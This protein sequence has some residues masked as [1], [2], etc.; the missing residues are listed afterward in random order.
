MQELYDEQ[1]F[2]AYQDDPKRR[3]MYGQEY[4]RIMRYFEPLT[5]PGAYRMVLDVGCGLGQFLEWFPERNWERHGVEVSQYAQA[6]C[7][8]KGIIMG[9]PKMDQIVDEHTGQF[10]QNIPAIPYDLV[11]FRGSLQHMQLPC[12]NLLSAHILLKP[13]GIL[14]ILATPDTESTCYRLWGTLPALNP[15]YNYHLFG[16]RQLSNALEHMGF[17]VLDVEHPYRDTPYANPIKDKL[18]FASKLLT[19]RGPVPCWPG[20]MMEIYAMKGANN[21]EVSYGDGDE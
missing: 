20:N 21:Y 19:G 12:A 13:G 5:K 10:I 4:T 17:D 6:V 16:A 11:I 15:A 3:E 18:R 8:S 1:Y 14:A 2:Q 7:K 9:W